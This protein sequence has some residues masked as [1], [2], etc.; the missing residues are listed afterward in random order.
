MLLCTFCLVFFAVRVR[1]TQQDT[2]VKCNVEMVTHDNM[3]PATIHVKYGAYVVNT[4]GAT[5]ALYY[6]K[7]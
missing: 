5:S 2:N 7:Q 1:V 3:E 4:D 6:C